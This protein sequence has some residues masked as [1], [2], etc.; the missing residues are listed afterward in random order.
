MA[1]LID[2]VAVVAEG[3]PD[4]V[5]LLLPQVSV[6]VPGNQATAKGVRDWTERETERKGRE[7]VRVENMEDFGAGGP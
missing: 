4:L 7:R 2:D 3:E 1:D 5:L 6:P